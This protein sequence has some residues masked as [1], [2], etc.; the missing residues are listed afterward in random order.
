MLHTV[1]GA[2]FLH[3]KCQ[4]VF[5]QGE[6]DIVVVNFFWTPDNQ[7]HTSEDFAEE[8]ECGIKSV[9][10]VSNVSYNL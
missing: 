10:E 5:V 1:N 6:I 4:Q 7:N 2:F 8:V 9:R 3:A